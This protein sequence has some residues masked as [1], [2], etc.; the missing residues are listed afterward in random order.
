MKNVI[1]VDFLGLKNKEKFREQLLA[2]WDNIETEDEKREV[3]EILID[4]LL[5]YAD[6]LK[7]YREADTKFVKD[8]QKLLPKSSGSST[9]SRIDK[10]MTQMLALDELA[11]M[12]E[13]GSNITLEQAKEEMKNV[14]FTEEDMSSCTT[15]EELL[16]T[17]EDIYYDQY[18]D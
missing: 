14:G 6:K 17:L 11:E 4:K 7:E 3:F 12:L 10:E 18:E 1:E 5:A 2:D 15:V 16:E 13:A 8:L 9:V